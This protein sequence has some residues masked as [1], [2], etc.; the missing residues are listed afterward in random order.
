MISYTAA[1]SACEAS[2]EFTHAENLFL[3]SKQLFPNIDKLGKSNMIDLHDLRAPVA[4]T[5]VR[6]ALADARRRCS[7][8]Q[9]CEDLI[10]ITGRGK[11]S[12]DNV[13]VLRPAILA[14]FQDQGEFH[15]VVECKD[16]VKNPGRV[17][18]SGTSIR[19]WAQRPKSPRA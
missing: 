18:I 5:V 14:M 11:G 12:V 8:D 10:V 7:G 2:G 19:R 1:I 15:G 16:N 3:R 13:S 9:E 4:R 6:I 17:I